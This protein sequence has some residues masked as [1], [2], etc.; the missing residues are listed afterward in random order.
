MNRGTVLIILGSAAV[1]AAIGFGLM[2]LTLTR[3]QDTAIE[4]PH[5]PPCMT[6]GGNVMP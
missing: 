3:A 5:T 2:F 4:I 1:G 6:W